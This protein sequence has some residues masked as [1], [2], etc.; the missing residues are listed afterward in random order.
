V[1]SVVKLHAYAVYTLR[2]HGA[3]SRTIGKLNDL[4]RACAEECAGMTTRLDALSAEVGT[5]R[6]ERDLLQSRLSEATNKPVSE[7]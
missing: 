1:D 4:L 2:Q 5:L 3:G 6:A 7:P